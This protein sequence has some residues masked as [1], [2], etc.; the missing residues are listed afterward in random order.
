MKMDDKRIQLKIDK[1]NYWDARVI[2]LECDYFADQVTLEYED[3]GGN[4]V[5]IFKSCFKVI[6]NH[7][8]GFDKGGPVKKLTREQLPYFLYD[9]EVGKVKSEGKELYTFKIEMN[10]MQIEI[11]C[12]DLE[13]QRYI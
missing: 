2:R 13:L 8:A 1:L 3:T 12:K 11:W 5:Y 6:F 4:V 7:F 10:P 9:V